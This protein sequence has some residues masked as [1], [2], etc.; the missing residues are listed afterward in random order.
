MR[1]ALN[2]VALSLEFASSK[3]A[4]LAFHLLAAGGP[5]P[6]AVSPECE[7]TQWLRMPALLTAL[8]EPAESGLHR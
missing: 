2:R 6:S 1:Q 8:P 5:L 3:D 7:L 4:A